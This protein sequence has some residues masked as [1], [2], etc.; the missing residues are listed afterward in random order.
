MA[1]GSVAAGGTLGALVPPFGAI[2]VYALFTETSIGQLFLA[3][4][5]PEILTISLYFAATALWLR[6]FAADAPSASRSERREIRAAL[7][8]SIPVICLFALVLGGLYAGVFT[9]TESA[10]AGAFVVALLRGRLRSGAFRSVMEKVVQ[11][12]AFIYGLIFGALMFS[13]FVNVTGVPDIIVR[14][15]A[16]FDMA[17]VA[18]IALLLAVY[19]ALGCVMDSFGIMVITLPAVVPI[20]LDY[21]LVWWGIVMVIETGLI[22][23]PF[24]INMFVLRSV[25]PDAPLTTVYQGVTPFVAAD[26]VKLAFII[27]FPVLSLWLPSM[28]F[29]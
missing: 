3:A 8:R 23:P 14:A 29:N 5:V 28:M 9:A 21:S 17:P 6:M 13:F 7:R 10:A 26:I 22:T 25:A 4:I 12:S 16:D 11:T 19:L 20:V 1:T 18:V 24:G 15:I 2:L 27:L